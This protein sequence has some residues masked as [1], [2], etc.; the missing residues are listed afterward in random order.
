MNSQR[1]LRPAKRLHGSAWVYMGLHEFAW[2][3]VGLQH[4][5]CVYRMPSNL[6]F[7]WDFWMHDQAGL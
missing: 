5:L 4:I 2:V 3:F 7:A 6:G 1:L